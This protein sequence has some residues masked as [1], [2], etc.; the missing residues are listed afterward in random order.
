MFGA[1][2]ESIPDRLLATRPLAVEFLPNSSP[3]NQHYMGQI[4]AYPIC[5]MLRGTNR[6]TTRWSENKGTLT[7]SSRRRSCRHHHLLCRC[8]PL[9]PL[10]LPLRHRR[11]LLARG[12]RRPPSD[13]EGSEWGQSGC[14]LRMSDGTPRTP[15][16]RQAFPMARREELF[17]QQKRLPPQNSRERQQSQQDGTD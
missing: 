15:W 9:R 2:G 8:L 6:Q 5:A 11:A 10:L 16:Q 14:I 1:P 12:S 3:P 7:P 4:R 13:L 17:E